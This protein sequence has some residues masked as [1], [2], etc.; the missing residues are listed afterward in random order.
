[1]NWFWH[2]FSA[3]LKSMGPI[4][5]PYL[6][7]PNRDLRVQFGLLILQFIF[8]LEPQKNKDQVNWTFIFTFLY[9]VLSVRPFSL[10]VW[11]CFGLRFLWRR[12]WP[13]V[14]G[15]GKWYKHK[16]WPSD[17]SPRQHEHTHGNRW[18]AR[19][20][21]I[22]TWWIHTR[23][24]THTISM[25]GYSS[26]AKCGGVWQR[27]FL[28]CDR[29][30]DPEKKFCFIT[31]CE[32]SRYV[33]FLIGIHMLLKR[34]ASDLAVIQKSSSKLLWRSLRWVSYLEKHHMVHFKLFFFLERAGNRSGLQNGQG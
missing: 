21:S 28:L 24:Q 8:I 25:D 33:F 13:S 15:T 7:L 19:S 31:C 6:S 1:M 12:R 10:L 30:V 11:L 4:V 26:A 20:L 14:S 17:G 3:L 34:L 32:R 27:C 22:G 16:H 9:D 29:E 23:S 18:C 2:E 5:I